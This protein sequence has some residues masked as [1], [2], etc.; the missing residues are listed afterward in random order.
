MQLSWISRHVV[1]VLRFEMKLRRFKTKCKCTN[2][3][4]I[5][6][7]VVLVSFK[8]SR[9]IVYCK[10]VNEKL[11]NGVGKSIQLI[12]LCTDQRLRPQPRVLDKQLYKLYFNAK[13]NCQSVHLNVYEVLNFMNEPEYKAVV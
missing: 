9:V 8:C 4:C 3:N 1:L 13:L 6:L 5:L 11:S 7:F 2:S 10:C 12:K